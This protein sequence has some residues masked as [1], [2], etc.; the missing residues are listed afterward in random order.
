MRTATAAVLIV[1]ALGAMASALIWARA[2]AG[3]DD[4]PV[5]TS[6][7]AAHQ[8]GPGWLHRPRTEPETVKAKLL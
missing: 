6:P 3:T 4:T 8:P 1:V 2:Q 5:V 7:A